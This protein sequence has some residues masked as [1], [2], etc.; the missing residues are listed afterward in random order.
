M[1][2]RIVF[3]TLKAS[4]RQPDGYQVLML[5][6]ALLNGL[7]LMLILFSSA[8]GIQALWFIPSMGILTCLVAAVLGPLTNHL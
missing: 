2:S 7:V 6:L 5:T 1:Q 8:P 3:H 4:L